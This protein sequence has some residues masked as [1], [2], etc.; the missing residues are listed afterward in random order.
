[1]NDELTCRQVLDL[2]TEYLEGA[3]P[4]RAHAAVADHLSACD[5]C[6]RYLD[7]LRTTVEVVGS[8]H[9]DEVPA[10]VRAGLVDSFRAWHLRDV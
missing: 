9:E 4:S 10:E 8:L 7:Q 6:L 1:M 5:V 3:L 2:L